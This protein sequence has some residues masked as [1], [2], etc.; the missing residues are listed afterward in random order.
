MHCVTTWAGSSVSGLKGDKDCILP[1]AMGLYNS[2]YVLALPQVGK[3][4]PLVSFCCSVRS[5]NGWSDTEVQFNF[6]S[7]LHCITPL[8]MGS[9]GLVTECLPW[10]WEIVCSIPCQ[11][12]PK[13]MKNGTYCF[14]AYQQVFRVGQGHTVYGC[15]DHPQSAS[16]AHHKTASLSLETLHPG[17]HSEHRPA[18]VHGL[19]PSQK[20]QT[21][22]FHAC[23]WSSLS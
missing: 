3:K 17:E 15:C 10:D 12:K 7:I 5:W 2:V 8:P 23:Q 18:H 13:T 20:T 16:L 14:S 9:L 19:K 1:S 6:R 11:V 22:L 21:A 4:D